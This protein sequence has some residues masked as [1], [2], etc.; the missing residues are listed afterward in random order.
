MVGGGDSLC[1]LNI[2]NFKRV[3]IIVD[4]EL[5]T[6]MDPLALSAEIDFRLGS[7]TLDP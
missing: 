2:V 1:N 6:D 3:L 7:A 4:L 5:S